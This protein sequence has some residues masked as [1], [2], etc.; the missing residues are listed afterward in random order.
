MRYISIPQT[1]L[2]VSAICMGTVFFGS[3]VSTED[4]FRIMDRFWEYGGNFFDTARIYGNGQPGVEPSPSEKTIGKWLRARGLANAAVIATKGGHP[5]KNGGRPTLG[6]E[7]LTRQAEESCQNLC[8][9]VI[10]LYYLHRDD[11]EVSVEYIMDTLFSLQDRGIVKHLGCSNW[12]A[13]RIIKA[14]SYAQ[15]NGRVGFAAV[16]NRWSLAEYALGVG[17]PTLVDM[18]SELYKMH[19]ET[20]IAAI[21]FSSTAGGYLSKLVSGSEI[22]PSANERYGLPENIILADRAKKLA[23]D[24]KVTVAQ[25]ALAYFYTHPFTAVPVTAFSNDSQ[26]TEAIGAASIQLSN[27]EAL[28]LSGK[29]R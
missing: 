15:A 19:T 1:D 14:N 6:R 3:A 29:Y 16:S 4:S 10:P 22:R 12:T 27:E 11:T 17:D 26:M 9:D 8:L 20:G 5:P 2:S 24:K 18:N 13:D 7:E 23:D 21:P 28:Y 25:I